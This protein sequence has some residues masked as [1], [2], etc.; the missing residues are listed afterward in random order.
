MGN[1]GKNII[2]GF[3]TYWDGF[4]TAWW[5]QIL[6][7]ALCLPVVT[8][9]LAFAGLY[10]TMY[11][12][13]NGESLEWNTFFEGIKLYWWPAI[14][15]GLVNFLVI[16]LLGSYTLSLVSSGNGLGQ[17]WEQVASG[18]T[19]GLLVIWLA[20][21][22]FTFPFMLAQESPSYRQALRNSMILYLKWPVYTLAF[23]VVIAAVIGLSVWLLVPWVILTSSLAA[24]MACV[25]VKNKVSVIQRR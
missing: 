17:D 8:I 14:R 13:A 25:C 9:P 20:I 6:W 15:W 10:H 3:I 11:Q 24:L 16:A 5:V 1:L 22:A 12:M 19:L 18:V 21:N 23:V 2:E 7:I 4:W